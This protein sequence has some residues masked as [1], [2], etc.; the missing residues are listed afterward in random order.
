MKDI[1]AYRRD[2]AVQYAHAWAYGRNPRYY[3]FSLL[4]GDC[5][6]FASQVLY[7]GTGVMNFTPTTGWFYIDANNRTPSW[8]GVQFFYNFL[9]GN[10]G[11][12]P[13]GKVVDLTFVEPGDFIQLSADGQRYTHTLAAVAVGRPATEHN[14]LVATHTFDSD[15]RPLESYSHDVRRC[16]H[17][18]GYRYR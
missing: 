13:F 6:N 11:P 12:G 18:L 8:T 15:N 17:I 2:K 3:D 9:I 14:V 10:K 4:G 16:I 5:T 1:S 7:A